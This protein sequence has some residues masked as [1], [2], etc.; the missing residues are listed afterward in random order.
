MRAPSFSSSQRIGVLGLRVFQG[1]HPD[2]WI[3]EGNPQEGG[4]F[5]FDGQMWLDTLGKIAGRFSFQLKAGVGIEWA[6]GDEP[7]VSVPLRPETCNVFLSDGHPI[8]LVFVALESATSMDSASMH[9]LWIED[10]IRERLGEREAF[11]ESDPAEMTFRVPVA[12]RLTKQLDISE[13]L[14]RHWEH[15]R[16]TGRLRSEEGTRAL[17]TVSGLSPRGISALTVTSSRQLDRWLSHDALSGDSVW[18]TPKAGTVASALKELSDAL[19]HGNLGESDRL[20]ARLRVEVGDDLELGAELDYQTGRRAYFDDDTA[21]AALLLSRASDAAPDKARYAAAALEAAVSASHDDLSKLP[22]RLR[23]RGDELSGEDDVRFQLARLAALEGDQ[24]RAETLVEQLSEPNRTKAGL[25]LSVI[26][27]DWTSVLARSRQSISQNTDPRT[28][29]FIKI[30]QARALLHQVT[31][32]EG[33][34][35]VGGTPG[36]GPETA[37][38]LRDATLEALIDA[39]SLGWPPNAQYLLDC[40]SAVAV[41]LGPDRELMGLVAEYSRKRPLLRDVQDAAA[42]LATF[43]G[44]PE[45]AIEALERIQEPRPED[46]AHLIMLLSETGRHEKAVSLA[47][48]ELPG[49]PHDLLTDMAAVAAAVSA[50]RLQL[51]SQ[52]EQLRRYL[53]SGH[54]AARSLLRYIT[55]S[56]RQPGER[57]SHLDQLWEDATAGGGDPNLQDNLFQYLRPDRKADIDRLI[58]LAHLVLKR[59]NLLAPEAARYATALLRRDRYDDVVAFTERALAFYPKDETIG[60]VRAIALDKLGQTAAAEGVLRQFEWSDRTD[61]VDARA[62]LLLRS[63]E[64]DAGVALVRRALGAAVEQDTKFHYQRL[65]AT[66]Y[67]RTDRTEYL[68]AV[69]RLG[70]L[71]RPDVEQEEGVYLLHLLM[72]RRDAG[73]PISEREA[74]DFQQRVE[75]FT[76]RFPES[77]ILRVGHFPEGATGAQMI[78]YLQTL[79]GLSENQ[80]RIQERQRRFGENSGSHLPFGLRPRTFAPFATN[81]VDLLRICIERWHDGE[82]SRLLVSDDGV[83]GAAPTAPPILDLVTVLALVELDLFEALF[84]RWSAIAVPKESIA[85]LTELM[86]APLEVGN[87][88]L[89]DRTVQAIRRWSAR[90]LQPS[91]GGSS[92][93]GYPLGEMAT[94]RQEVTSGRY[95]YLSIDAA[96]A[97]LVALDDQPARRC[98]TVWPFIDHAQRTGAITATEASVVR[99][100]VASWNSR[101]VPLVPDDV[102]LAALGEVESGGRDDRSAAARAAR[103]LITRVPLADAL[104]RSAEVLVSLVR[105]TGGGRTAAAWFLRLLYMEALVARAMGFS[106]TADDLTAHLAALC[107]KDVYEA[108]DAEAIVPKLWS[109]LGE[110]R[111]AWGGTP[112][113]DQFFRHIGN[114]AAT[115]FHPIAKKHGIA[116]MEAEEA[117]RNL[118][119]SFAT[120]G[121]QDRE[122]LTMAY[123]DKTIDLHR[124]P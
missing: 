104:G 124:S 43:G 61:L 84:S 119:F 79:V 52:E 31:D 2:Q 60:L 82:A 97:V 20:I 91:A 27:G 58:E 67:S 112:D 4:D 48:E 59:R 89:V 19:S 63:G 62:Q 115:L 118:L 87:T 28:R 3:P 6:G 123:F 49:M 22:E 93:D 78:A 94:L 120:P 47:V 14:R 56:L 105:R 117:F 95:A 72:A 70:E 38:E 65:L 1:G 16:L 80:I 34:I 18:A 71:A 40:A 9:Y 76:T 17:R 111:A 12:N 32:G 116:A 21:E 92:S 44:A 15:N 121:T 88:D 36:L 64:V 33:A 5:G 77:K 30:F 122:A 55:E 7:Y 114:I 35:A 66:L 42:R 54:S 113:G 109:I 100:R 106:G 23:R 8:L 25:L 99:L 51:T 101:G 81:V 96:A 73:V 108:P 102:C 50:F 13:H 37:K 85:Y 98:T 10:A 11:D 57:Q 110:L 24:T 90:I 45:D 103:A 26:A 39:Q 53:D 107:V 46:I 83:L 69:L 29:M 74:E 41:T 75:A 68:R 86:F